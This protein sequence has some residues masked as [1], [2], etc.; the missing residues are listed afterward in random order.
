MVRKLAGVA[1]VLLA[2]VGAAVA[3]AQEQE[4]PFIEVPEND[5]AMAAAISQGRATLSRFWQALQ[6]PQPDEDGFALKVALPTRSGDAEHIWAGSIERVGDK[7][8]GTINN[9]PRD[10][11][12]IRLGERIEIS[13]PLIS[14]WMYQRSGKIVGG[15][16][17][18]ALLP[19]LSRDEAAR[20]R[21][22]LAEP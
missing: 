16:T 20:L 2:L 22:M 1:L 7:I 15:Y 8:Y 5:P 19:R 12:D 14:D 3:G 11:K 13:E 21:A 17:I 4:P 10:L 18:R 6:E 9:V